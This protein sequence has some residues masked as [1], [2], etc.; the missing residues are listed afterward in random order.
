MFE[1]YNNFLS[2]S[3]P[4]TSHSETKK[5]IKQEE[6]EYL[7]LQFVNEVTN[8]ILLTGVYSDK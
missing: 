4:S 1:F 5:L 6:E 8:D 2:R 7:Y 3:R